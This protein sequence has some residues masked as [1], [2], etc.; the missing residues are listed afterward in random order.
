MRVWTPDETRELLKL[1]PVASASQIGEKLQRPRAA[2]I[3]KALRLRSQGALP[4]GPKHFDINPRKRPRPRAMPP[5]PPQP[6]PPPPPPGD[7][8]AMRP[9]SIL[10]LEAGRC[11]WPLGELTAVATTFCGGA[12][13]PGRRY[14]VHHLRIARSE[15][16][17]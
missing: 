17:G 7:S 8:L 15:H 16:N 3:S 1:W 11:H 5:P 2:V 13:L 6:P 9:C 14:C 10:E 12:T 4:A